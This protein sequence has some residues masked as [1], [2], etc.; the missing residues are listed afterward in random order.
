MNNF[1][2]ILALT[3]PR[4][5]NLMAIKKSI[6]LAKKNQ[7]HLTVLSTK[8]K[9]SPYHQFFNK[10]EKNNFNNEQQIL[11]L[12]NFA[13]REGISTHYKVREE[14]DQLTALKNQLKTNEYD[15]VVADHQQ[16]ETHLWPFHK[17]EDSNLLNASDTSILFVGRHKWQSHGNVL[18][19]IET[20][21][22]TLVHN[23]FNNEIIVKTRDLA[24]LLTSNIHLF[25]CYFDSC[26]VSFKEME[27]SKK[28]EEFTHHLEHLTRLAKGYQLEDKCLHVEEGLADDVIPY[29]AH[30]FNANVVVMGCGEHKGW[31]A[32]IKGHT[33]D[34]VLDKLNCDLLALK[35]N[36]IH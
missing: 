28:N 36:Q 32:N 20:E 30:K 24:K 9:Y 18:A 17:A 13:K 3:Q 34:Y 25:N 5:S 4:A 19:A 31:L 16:E 6:I 2:N 23:K 1:S 14:R 21:E 33:I 15:L 10:T 27:F 29:Q 8:K 26:S 11:E 35:Y 7:A 22:N 12:V